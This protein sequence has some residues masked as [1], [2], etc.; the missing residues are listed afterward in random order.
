MVHKLLTI[1]EVAEILKVSYDT[2]LHIAKYGNLP[3]TCVGKQ[4]R[5]SEE[6]LKNY[7]NK[8]KISKK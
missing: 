2:A 3:Y 4:Y 1:K 7:L 8:H 5:V 6:D